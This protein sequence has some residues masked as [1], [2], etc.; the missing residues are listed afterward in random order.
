MPLQIS[1]WLLN[2]CHKLCCSGRPPPQRGGMRGLA[3]PPADCRPPRLPAHVCASGLMHLF[4]QAKK[5]DR[6]PPEGK[7][8]WAKLM[9]PC[10]MQHIPHPKVFCSQP[11]VPFLGFWISRRTPSWSQQ[12]SRTLIWQRGK[13]TLKELRVLLPLPHLAHLPLLSEALL[14]H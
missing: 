13:S 3:V 2:P 4:H 9:N 6:S 1:H 14:I 10:R 12:A 8:L 11:L 7:I 5:M